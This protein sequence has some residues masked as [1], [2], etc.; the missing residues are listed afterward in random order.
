MAI[1]NLEQGVPRLFENDMRDS[2][3]SGSKNHE[4]LNN[5]IVTR[6]RFKRGTVRLGYKSEATVAVHGYS[7]ENPF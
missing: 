1:S 3:W 6:M 7:D 5:H 2:A 4:N